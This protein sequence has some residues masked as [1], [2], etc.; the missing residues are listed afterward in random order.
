MSD[1]ILKSNEEIFNS[2]FVPISK[3]LIGTFG[4]IGRIAP[5]KTS[6]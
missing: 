3:S 2:N 1:K 4:K 6:N 5:E